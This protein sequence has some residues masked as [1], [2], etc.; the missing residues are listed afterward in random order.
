M[1][2][3]TTVM[4]RGRLF[5]SPIRHQINKIHVSVLHLDKLL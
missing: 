5:I 1:I 2:V 3:P 4:K